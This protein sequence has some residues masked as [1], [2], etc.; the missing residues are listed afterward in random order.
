MEISYQEQTEAFCT[1]PFLLSFPKLTPKIFKVLADIFIILIRSCDHLYLD[2]CFGIF[3]LL[4]FP[5]ENRC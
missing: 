1:G 2:N 5:N 4:R 3:K